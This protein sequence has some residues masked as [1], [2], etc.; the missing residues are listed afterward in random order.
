MWY[1]RYG[2]V[3]AVPTDLPGIEFLSEYVEPGSDDEESEEEARRV[4]RTDCSLSLH[5]WRSSACSCRAL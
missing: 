1:G 3:D 2:E 5:L 4:E